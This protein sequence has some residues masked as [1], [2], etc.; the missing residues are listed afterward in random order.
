MIYPKYATEF[1][2]LGSACEDTCCNGW[3]VVIDQG[4]YEKYQTLPASPLRALID[5]S[6]LRRP[7]S[8]RE[9]PSKFSIIQMEPS[10]GCPMQSC[11]G[12]CRVQMEL[13]TDYL[14]DLCTS[15]PRATCTVDDIKIETLSQGC[16]EAVR[17]V[18]GNPD[19]LTSKGLGTGYLTWDDKPAKP[20]DLRAYFW[21]IREF[22]VTLL[23]NRS[24]AL[25]QRMFLLGTF[26]RRLEA[27]TRHEV[28]GGYAAMEGGFS[29]AI[30]GGGLR[31]SIETIPAHNAHQLDMVLHLIKSPVVNGTVSPRY[32][33]CLHS[34]MK[35]IGGGS[36]A[37]FEE[38][39]AAYS[40]A[41][42]RF[43][44]P[45]FQEH[46]YMLENLLTDMVFHTSFPFGAD[47]INPEAPV[48]PVRQF[49]DLATFF[50]LIKGLLIGVAGSYQEA[51]SFDHVVQTVQVIGKCFG[52]TP[53]FL[54]YGQELLNSK[55][56]NDA[57]G[58]TM[59]LRN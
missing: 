52:H 32:S 11:E 49:A 46:P 53:E 33:E 7:D 8:G 12:L 59:L 24:Y 39:T 57:Q 36:I 18:L 48:Q 23:Q 1:R 30:A 13:G 54:D 15:F 21:P 28:E 27:V 37:T 14:S 16:P 55:G 2:C 43:Y 34:F 10:T 40:T 44:A 26:C 58:L 42:E 9:D 5:R 38:Q 3:N 45:F 20:R 17:L 31:D 47:L 19:L 29:A 22:V 35:G 4:T 25:W 41:Y 51:F 56:L 6:V 50:A